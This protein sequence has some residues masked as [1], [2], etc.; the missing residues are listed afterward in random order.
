MT[1][2]AFVM[3]K[4]FPKFGVGFAIMLKSEKHEWIR[5]VKCKKK[6]TANQAE[7]QA[8]KY[9]GLSI[10]EGMPKVKIITKNKYISFMF[11]TVDGAWKKSVDTIELNREIVVGARSSLSELNGFVVELQEEAKEFDILNKILTNTIKT[12]DEYFAKQGDEQGIL[13]T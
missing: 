11:E 2:E 8:V 6:I 4:N 10:K 5:A 1:I 7:L 3:S 13:K 12:G 9:V